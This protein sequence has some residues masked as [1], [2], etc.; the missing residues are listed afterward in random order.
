MITKRWHVRWL[1][2][3]DNAEPA[4]VIEKK[5]VPGPTPVNTSYS[6]LCDQ[7]MNAQIV[8]VKGEK[9]KGPYASAWRLYERGILTACGTTRP[10]PVLSELVELYAHRSPSTS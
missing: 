3:G 10:V 6:S 5:A 4:M 2:Q 9:I 7:I 8:A 1:L